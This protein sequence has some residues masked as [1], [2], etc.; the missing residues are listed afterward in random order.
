MSTAL[1]FSYS[2][3]QQR[4]DLETE[5]T[6][7][8]G[9]IAVSFQRRMSHRLSLLDAVASFV[10]TTNAGDRTVLR[11][12][13]A[14]LARNT[15]G[16][17]ALDWVPRVPAQSLASYEEAQW[18]TGLGD[19][20]VHRSK[21]TL[22]PAAEYFPLHLGL[23]GT[24]RVDGIDMTPG[25]DLSAV[26]SLS[27]TLAAARTR[28][29]IVAA[30]PVKLTRPEGNAP[31]VVLVAPVFARARSSGEPA[32]DSDLLGYVLGIFDI[33]LPFEEALTELDRASIGIELRDAAAG[34]EARTLYQRQ[35]LANHIDS[36]LLWLWQAFGGGQVQH[37][38][39]LDQVGRP[40]AIATWAG[41]R[42]L[43]T[44][45][46]WTPWA[47]LICGLL[48]TALAV[49]SSQAFVSRG[50]QLGLVRERLA[51]ER[52]ENM[53][54]LNRLNEELERERLEQRRTEE[55]LFR[56]KQQFR[57]MFNAVPAM[58]WYKDTKNRFLL[59]NEAAAASMGRTVKEMEGKPC[60]EIL[61]AK[62][63]DL[64]R[65]DLEIIQSGKPKLGVIEELDLPS[66]KSIWI[67]T[68]KLPEYDSMGRVVGILVFAQDI[69]ERLTA[70]SEVR[71][72][73]AE[74]E[75]RVAARTAELRAANHELESFAYSVSHDLRTPL[76]TIDGFSQLVLD[77][78]G[79]KLDASGLE[80]LE[81]VRSA[82]QR[83]GHLIDDLLKLTR[84]S[85]S[86]LR[87]EPLDLSALARQVCDDLRRNDPGRHVEVVIDPVPV[88]KGDPVLMLNVMQNLL[89]NAWKFTSRAEAA[90]IEFGSLTTGEGRTAYYVRD[91]GV[92]F[93]MVYVEKLFG[94]FQRLHAQEDFEGS[95][96]GLA[97][98]QMILRRH[99]GEVWAE[100]VP[101]K[102][103][104]FYF[105]I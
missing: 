64:Y 36:A 102:G 74:L 19:F 96:I 7:R 1:A 50:A 81:R 26:P 48:T 92:G 79:S 39:G 18:V 17:V 8:T 82:S 62:A 3:L 63:Y 93:D 59:V 61:P 53:E 83:M 65:D 40:W 43:D 27:A 68:D 90:R 76:R 42:F 69:T 23:S 57:L 58:I 86:E 78:F 28:A 101:G 45:L 44:R 70:E 89:G 47:V 98:V 29:A 72:L 105:S 22:A 103:A 87:R 5:L 15:P 14:D 24:T 41:P 55:S 10:V 54:R 66:R 77:E 20:R 31:G 38:M 34:P 11:S 99:G 97:T 84:V 88:A 2:F 67:R 30:P 21:E 37:T 33:A 32:R 94:A 12:F 91:N 100:G 75:Q 35:A 25:S 6:R 95:G 9:T 49:L 104:T 60:S 80:Y 85:R 46:Q 71:R 16:V 56:E 52:A 13:A 4:R 73:N 51:R